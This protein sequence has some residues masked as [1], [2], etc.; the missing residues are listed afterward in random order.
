MLAVPV[1]PSLVAVIVAVPAPTPVTRPVAVFTV[2]T[3]AALVVHVTVRPVRVLPLASFVTAVSCWVAPTA[4]VTAAGVTETLATGTWITLSDCWPVRPLTVAMT[5][6][7]PGVTPMMTPLALT[8]A[9]AGDPE[10][11]VTVPMAIDPPFW[12]SPAALADAVWPT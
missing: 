3:F 8:V 2:A 10:D 5:A 7:W 9:T 4:N 6:A 11:H 1:F 12:S